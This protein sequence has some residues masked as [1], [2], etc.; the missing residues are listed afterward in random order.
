MF[1]FTQETLRLS[2]VMEIKNVFPS[3]FC[4]YLQ[5][6]LLCSERQNNT[7]KKKE[8]AQT[9]PSATQKLN[10]TYVQRQRDKVKV[11]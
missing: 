2:A 11:S 7:W 3:V 4:I 10:F 5:S 1:F 8:I 9:R 6:Y